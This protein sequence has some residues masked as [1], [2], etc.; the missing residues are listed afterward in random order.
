M[1]DIKYHRW[2]DGGDDNEKRKGIQTEDQENALTR[3]RNNH[4]M[5]GESERLNK[6]AMRTNC[7]QEQEK[8]FKRRTELKDEFDQEI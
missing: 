7:G 8:C 6:R 2:S 4:R 3:G 5:E 1:I